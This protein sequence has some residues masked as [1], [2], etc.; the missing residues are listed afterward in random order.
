M[1]EQEK[2]KKEQDQAEAM[3]TIVQAVTPE[4]IKLLDAREPVRK[5]IFEDGSKSERKELEDKKKQA[6]DYLKAL[7][8]NDMVARKDLSSGLTS[9]GAEL[10][11][12]YI[13]D[14]VILQKQKYGL[15]EKY[16]Q[17]FPME[18]IHEDIPTFTTATA[19][20]SNTDIS[21]LQSSSPLTGSVYL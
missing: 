18:G 12:T 3:Q 16:A 20:R 17:K 15:V 8:R 14:Q 13:S 1:N 6:A 21:A 9:N 2:L 10:V 5:N 4:V 11:P 19:Y 7:E